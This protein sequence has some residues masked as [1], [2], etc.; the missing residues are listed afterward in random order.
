MS[1]LSKREKDEIIAAYRAG[2][3]S[4]AIGRRYG[5][6]SGWVRK[7]AA[8]AGVVVKPPRETSR[9]VRNVR[10]PRPRPVIITPQHIG[11]GRHSSAGYLKLI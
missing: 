7:L 9:K 1:R 3:T 5:V 10:E 11:S 6:N 2:E 8:R 4:T